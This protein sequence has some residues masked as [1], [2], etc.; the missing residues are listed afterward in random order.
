MKT[1]TIKGFRDYSGKDA[2]KK[3]IIREVIRQ[4]FE[5]YGFNPVETPVIESEEFVKGDNA[6]DEAV[7]DIYKLKDRGKR[8]LA[9][10]YE[11]T[12]Q[13]KRLVKNKKLPYKCYQIGELF[14][15]EPIR[16]G[17]NRQFTQCDVDIVGSTIKDEAEILAMTSEIFKSLKVDFTILINNRKLLNEILDDLKI[18]KN[19]EQV[20]RE[21]DK[22]DKQPMQKTRD[23][24]S[25]LGA[26]KLL[27]VINRGEKYFVKFDSYKEIKSLIDY[28]K[29]YGIKVKFAPSLVR[30]LAYYNGS[31]FEVWSKK[32]KVSICGGGSYLVN[33]IQS[34][35]ISFG[36][37]PLLLIAN[38][39]VDIEK[40]LV[41]SLE[42]DRQAI[43]LAQKLR[44]QGKIVGMYYGKPSKAMEYANSYGFQK[45]I[46]VGEREV[47]V[48]KLKI[49]VMKSGKESILKF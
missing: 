25:K 46:F 10:R 11:F 32:L 38:L 28:C 39:L 6:D 43:K 31:V 20:L 34:T 35:G 17:R 22:L 41:V 42:Q 18:K 44:K 9:L 45:V 26:E 15:D 5:R 47:K 2:E 29:V 33:G 21:I 1:E 8:K 12:F 23:N 13:L 16:E 27:K 30:G 3:A 37:T 7:R 14:R 24:L 36:L 48:K 19:R 4:V 40:Y 49:K